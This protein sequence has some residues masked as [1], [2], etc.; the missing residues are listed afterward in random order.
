[1]HVDPIKPKLKPPGCKLL[2]LK[3]DV[4]LSNFAFKFNLRRY[5]LIAKL[6]KHDVNQR[7]GCGR[8]GSRDV[9]QHRWF[10]KMDW[11]MLERK[12]VK[13]RTSAWSVRSTGS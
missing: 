2:K 7:L 1:V 4:L 3:C 10:S 11:N 6:L 13:A 12:A 8:A 9:K 5:N